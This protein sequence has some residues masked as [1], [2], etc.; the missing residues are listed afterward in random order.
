[1]TK[2]A[3][4]KIQKPVVNKSRVSEASLFLVLAFLAVVA[5]MAIQ[6]V[7]GL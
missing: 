3:S 1:M 7:N 6:S 4:K 5:I 2:K